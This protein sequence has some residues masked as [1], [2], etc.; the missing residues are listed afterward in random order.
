VPQSTSPDGVHAARTEP[1]TD[2]SDGR[3]YLS[4]Y[5]KKTG[6]IAGRLPIGGYARYPMDADPDNLRLLWSP[7]SKHFAL[8]IRGTKRSWTTTV[9]AIGPKGIQ[10]VK[11]PSPTAKAL[12]VVSG[13][14]IDRAS[15]ETPSK[16]MDN[17][18]LVLRASGDTMING[19]LIWFEVDLTCSLKSGKITKAKIVETKRDEG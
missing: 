13:S 14:K 17:D 4:L 6:E 7:D 16:W 10:K 8:M 18:T 1:S 3:D 5:R 9:Y 15:R 19:K 2:V 11:L 12:E